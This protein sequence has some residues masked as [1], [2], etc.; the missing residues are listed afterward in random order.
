MACASSSRSMTPTTSSA[1][2]TPDA[3]DDDGIAAVAP[4]HAGNHR[5]EVGVRRRDH[6]IGLHDLAQRLPTEAVGLVG[7]GGEA[8][9]ADDALAVDDD[10]AVGL[11]IDARQGLG[12]GHAHFKHVEI[13]LTSPRAPAGRGTCWW[14]GR[15]GCPAALAQ[16]DGVDVV[17]D[18]RPAHAERHAQRQAPAA[19]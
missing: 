4:A 6:E 15:W 12:N 8:D 18:Q 1:R 9:E 11:D 7:N 19:G 3:F 10:D 2:G 13:A 14:C 16:L 5:I 17:D